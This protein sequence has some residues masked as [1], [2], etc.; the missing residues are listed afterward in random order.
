MLFALIFLLLLPFQSSAAT[1]DASVV[2]T[3]SYINAATDLSSFLKN[4]RVNIAMV[5]LSSTCPNQTM[6]TT[7]VPLWMDARSSCNNQDQVQHRILDQHGSGLLLNMTLARLNGTLKGSFCT[8]QSGELLP[9]ENKANA[10]PTPS[11]QCPRSLLSPFTESFQCDPDHLQI[12]NQ[13]WTVQSPTLN[14][15]VTHQVCPHGFSRVSFHQCGAVGPD[16]LKQHLPTIDGNVTHIRIDSMTMS[17]FS[18]VHFDAPYARINL[19]QDRVRLPRPIFDI[20]SSNLQ[21]KG[22]SI[23]SKTPFCTSN[24]NPDYLPTLRF[25]FP[26]STGQLIHLAVAPEDYWSYYDPT[27]TEISQARKLNAPEH[28]L[29]RQWCLN[30]VPTDSEIPT[31][32]RSAFYSKYVSMDTLNNQVRFSPAACS[33]P[34]LYND[35]AIFAFNTMTRDACTKAAQDLKVPYAASTFLDRSVVFSVLGDRLRVHAESGRVCLLGDRFNW[36]YGHSLIETTAYDPFYEAQ[37]PVYIWNLG[38]GPSRSV[39]LPFLDGASI[40]QLSVTY[41]DLNQVQN[42]SQMTLAQSIMDYVDHNIPMVLDSRITIHPID[43]PEKVPFGVLITPDGLV[44]VKLPMSFS[45]TFAKLTKYFWSDSL[46]G[47]YASLKK[48][49]AVVKDTAGTSY[50]HLGRIMLKCRYS[51]KVRLV[52]IPPLNLTRTKLFGKKIQWFSPKGFLLLALELG[53][54]LDLTHCGVCPLSW[55]PSLPKKCTHSI[56]S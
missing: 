16:A 43:P 44:R 25:S 34:H 26:S 4:V 42:T 36:N 33:S 24:L 7:L 45:D 6:C 32:G 17:G 3:F 1:P 53:N 15:C 41:T 2:T 20:F 31:L 28:A 40:P 55:Y 49:E 37:I 39:V 47:D 29:K 9:F 13:T 46:Y 18:P 51:S 48:C 50:S 12:S 30:I 11:K 54:R 23:L 56:C 10:I 8:G 38:M 21:S 27:S 14:R 22:V 52:S 5:P 19:D 35:H